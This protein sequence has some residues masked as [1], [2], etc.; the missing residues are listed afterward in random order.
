MPDVTI[1]A[2]SVPSE[3]RVGGLPQ[4]DEERAAVEQHARQSA[5]QIAEINRKAN[6]E[7][8]R[9]WEEG[10]GRERWEAAQAKTKAEQ[11]AIDSLLDDIDHL[12]LG[13]AATRELLRRMVDQWRS[14]F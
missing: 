2:P 12:R 8:R 11:E 13:G 7:V 14:K 5:L 1:G 3:S 10:G 4:T 9:A 6:E